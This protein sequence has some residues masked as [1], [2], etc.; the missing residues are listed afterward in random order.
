MAKKPFSLANGSSWSTRQ[1][2]IAHFTEMLG[3]YKVDETVPQGT[4]HDDLL[5]LLQHYDRDVPQGQETKI[6][7][8]VERFAKGQCRGEGFTRPCFFV[9]RADGS[10]DDFSFIK[11][12]RS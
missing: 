11:A 10:S 9:H 1:E 6:G 3:R 12:V 4:D 8:G 5:A 2:A 7:I